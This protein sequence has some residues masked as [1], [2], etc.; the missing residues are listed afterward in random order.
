MHV[1]TALW[2]AVR[3][4][5]PGPACNGVRPGAQTRALARARALVRALLRLGRC[6]WLWFGPELG[7]G[8]SLGLVLWALGAARCGAQV[9]D[10]SGGARPARGGEGPYAGTGPGLVLCN[11]LLFVSSKETVFVRLAL[12]PCCFGGGGSAKRS[13]SLRR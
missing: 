9:G 3:R 1:V 8:S 7:A 10:K 11:F 2:G 4:R 13:R 5:L 6:P 12:S